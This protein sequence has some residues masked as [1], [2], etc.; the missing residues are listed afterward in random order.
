ML[1]EID[2]Y[3]DIEKHI[4]LTKKCVDV[5]EN[6]SLLTGPD[7]RQVPEGAKVIKVWLFDQRTNHLAMP[8]WARFLQI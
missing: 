1:P 8:P 3:Y 4:E 5:L 2:G 6:S 7:C